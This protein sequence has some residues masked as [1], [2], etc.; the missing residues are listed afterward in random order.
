M[1]VKT[2]HGAVSQCQSVSGCH[3]ITMSD[4][5]ETVDRD[6][7]RSRDRTES[8]EP[9]PEAGHAH[10]EGDN[11]E[12][13]LATDREKSQENEV[14]S[15]G[16]FVEAVEAEIEFTEPVE[17]ETESETYNEPKIADG[18]G[19][20]FIEEKITV[21]DSGSKDEPA[22]LD[23]TESPCT[24]NG[25]KTENVNQEEE[26]NEVVENEEKSKSD[27]VEI[28][29]DERAMMVNMFKH[30]DSD[31]TG[32]MSIAELGNFMRAI[33]EVTSNATFVVIN[34]WRPGM[35]P[36]DDE[37]DDLLTHMDLDKSGMVDQEELIR[38]MSH[39]VKINL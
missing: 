25:N 12:K 29:D 14:P 31:G 3:H 34:D 6:S 11:E 10:D 13:S 24:T 35:F 7:V 19:V 15:V 8:G 33:G 9:E 18:C 20:E 30:F 39:Q 23:P 17:H 1:V 16:N 37:V 2:P 32:A 5:E 38:Q 4:C 21:D 22:D 26:L 27:E 28:S 36:T